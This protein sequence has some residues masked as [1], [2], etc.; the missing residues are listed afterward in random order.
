MEHQGTDQTAN[1]EEVR[2][3]FNISYISINLNPV[4]TDQLVASKEI[5]DT[6]TV[7][8]IVSS[9]QMVVTQCDCCSYSYMKHISIN[10]S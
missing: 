8:V 2:Y 1:G 10:F 4:H 9:V 7:A 5:N 6:V 3:Q